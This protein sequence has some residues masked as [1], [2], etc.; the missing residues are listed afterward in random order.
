METF[1][2]ERAHF[3][4]NQSQ[5]ELT[6]SIRRFPDIIGSGVGRNG[7]GEREKKKKSKRQ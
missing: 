3:N 5:E 7:G 1:I 4:V 2:S 6:D